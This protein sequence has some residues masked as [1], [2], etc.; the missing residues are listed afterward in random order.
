[1]LEYLIYLFIIKNKLI[2]T[3]PY[4]IHI[5]SLSICPGT[6]TYR[7]K[8]KTRE[9]RWV[10]YACKASLGC[11]LRMCKCKGRDEETWKGSRTTMRDG[12]SLRAI[13]K[14]LYSKLAMQIYT[15]TSEQTNKH[16]NQLY[17]ASISISYIHMY[18]MQADH[19]PNPPVKFDVWTS[20]VRQDATKCM[21]II[22]RRSESP[23]DNRNEWNHI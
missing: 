21:C 22:K 1:M 19:F 8:W 9:G 11:P 5:Y 3:I 15:Q 10:R 16:T 7:C 13:L 18:R 20:T 2:W 6:S 17:P 14:L 12:R 4:I 23:E